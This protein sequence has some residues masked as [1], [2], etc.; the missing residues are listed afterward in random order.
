MYIT[1][2]MLTSLVR[3]VSAFSLLV[4]I[5]ADLFAVS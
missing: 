4:D 2:L 3:L 1:G 5:D